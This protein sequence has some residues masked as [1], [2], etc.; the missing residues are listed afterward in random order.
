MRRHTLSAGLLTLLTV[1]LTVLPGAPLPA[2]IPW[3]QALTQQ[4][5]GSGFLT[6][7]P[8]NVST[9]FG[10]PKA[11]DGTDVRQ[12][13]TKDGHR[14]RTFNVSVASH[15][16]LVVFNVDAQ[17][18]ATTAYLL[19]AEGELR[20]AVSY[21]AGGEAQPLPPADAKA[22]FARE[23]RYWSARAKQAPAAAPAAPATAPAAPA[24]KP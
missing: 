7:L 9:A 18:G 1:L 13:L 19:T 5:L 3:A 12:L 16:D 6:R 24:T 23:K 17:S 10:L 11:A 22:G 15:A 21:K 2:A 20:K 8:P 4:A 14:I